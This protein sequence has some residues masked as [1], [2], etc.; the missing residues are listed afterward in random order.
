MKKELFFLI[1]AFI[2]GVLFRLWFISLSPQPF[3]WDQYEYEMYA[4]KIFNH[5][6]MMASHSYRSYPYPLLLALFYNVVGFGNHQAVFFLQAVMDS[7]VGLMIYVILR[8][9]MKNKSTAGI[10]FLLYTINPF[11]SGYVG[12]LL[13]EVLTGFFIAGTV[14]LGLL[15][16]KKPGIGSG[17]LFGLFAGLAAETRNAAFLWAAIPIG[18]AFS[19]TRPCLAKLG[20]FL[21]VLLTVLYPLYV[22]WRDYRELNVTTVDDFYAKEFFQG[23]LIKKLPPFT[24]VY[25]PESVRMWMEYYSEY[26]PG[27][28]TQ[29]RQAMAKKYYGMAWAI[30]KADPVDYIKVRFYK[31]W[32]VWQKEN[33]FF[34]K[35]PGFE[36]HRMVT[37]WGN[38]IL[39]L[40]AFIGLFFWPKLQKLQ[41]QKV[42]PFRFDF[43]RWSIIG[44]VLYGT[45]AF[46]VTHAEYRLTIPFYPL[47]ILASSVGIA[48]IIHHV[49]NV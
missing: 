27:R 37:Y 31:M 48:A 34:Y 26:D 4:L 42:K 2:G 39:L 41:P 11:T 33:V 17:V 15:F 14:L 49:R 47:V 23:A 16:V 36:N 8:Y 40:F 22:N 44:T 3:G 6:W 45:L 30:M 20:I 10:G 35:E 43:V 5:P 38:A 21:G 9:G 46:S 18:L 28:T 32:Y 24:Y 1:L 19:F 7:F 25:P 12:V 13:A 29:T